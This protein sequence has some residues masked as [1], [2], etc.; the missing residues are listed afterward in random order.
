MLSVYTFVFNQGS[1]TVLSGPAE[2][3]FLV[4]SF[5]EHCRH[6]HYLHVGLLE[7]G[8]LTYQLRATPAFPLSRE[9][10]NPDIAVILLC[11]D[12]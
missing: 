7:P 3:H 12:G 10:D 1:I 11:N 8:F 5:W 2:T 4:K 9:S 6:Y